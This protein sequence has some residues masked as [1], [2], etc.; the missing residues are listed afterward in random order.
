MTEMPTMPTLNEWID[1][2]PRKHHAKNTCFDCQKPCRGF[3]CNEHAA[4]A[5]KG[6]PRGTPYGDPGKHTKDT[7][8]R[9]RY[10]IPTPS[11]DSSPLTLAELA[12]AKCSAPDGNPDICYPETNEIAE[13]KSL[14]Y[15]CPLA[16]RCL[17]VAIVNKEGWGVWGG[18]TP[19]ER[20]HIRKKDPRRWEAA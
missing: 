17:T 16:A 1:A 10:P 18:A 7:S 15:G 14:C 20:E 13:A 2:A 9:M 12:T 19:T 11:L 4:Q 5:R 6:K 8:V 3:R